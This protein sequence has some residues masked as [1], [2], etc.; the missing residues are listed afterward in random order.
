[1]AAKVKIHS[2]VLAG[3]YMLWGVCLF[4]VIQRFAAIF[5]DFSIQ[6]PFPKRAL[7]AVGPYG[8][9]LVAM[10]PGILVV[11]KDRRYLSPW[12]NPFLTLLLVFW[13]G[14]TMLALLSPMFRGTTQI[15]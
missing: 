7:F 15:H 10:G 6:L 5:S 4:L 3:A 9:L 11:R 1:M 13:I 2:W 14:W 8:W 12:W